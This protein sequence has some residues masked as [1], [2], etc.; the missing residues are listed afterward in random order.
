[1]ERDSRPTGNGENGESGGSGAVR[2]RVGLALGPLLL[3]ATLLLPAPAGLDVPAWRTAGVGLWMATWW[4]TEAIPIPATSLLP[5]VLLPP[6]GVTGIHATA[7]PYAHE[8]IFLFLGGFLVAIG[9]ERWGVP[10]RLALALVSRAG[11]RPE[12]VIAAFMAS[13]AFLSMWISNTATAMLM[14]PIGLSVLDLFGAAVQGLETRGT[15][16]RQREAR[17]REAQEREAR[18][19]EA[20]GSEVRGAGGGNFGRALMLAIAYA[21]SIGGLGTLIGT[22]PNAFLA[23]YLAQT[24]GFE[25]GFAGW[26]AFGLPLV[27]VGLP[28]AHVL[29]TRVVYPA[30]F[31]ELPGGVSAVR[32][33]LRELGSPGPAERRVAGVFAAVALLW[34][35]RPVLDGWIPALSDTG[36][37]IAAGL[38][39]F[40]IPSG[41]GGGALLRWRDAERLPWGVLVLF[42]G[43]LSLADAIHS[44]GLTAWIGEATAGLAGWPLVL[45]VGGTALVV[46]LLTELTSNTA[47]A[48]AFLPI[49]ASVAV[50]IGQ[51]PLLLTVPAAVTASCAFMLPVATPPNA[52]V[53]GSGVLT[54]PQMARAGIWLNLL[55]VVLATGAALLLLPLLFGV[56]FGTVPGWA[57]AG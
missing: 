35:S 37:A 40:L 10:R 53:Y 43:G 54:V 47:T 25:L 27:L 39:L 29:L 49:L 44:S 9:L 8:L 34:M 19:R 48:A 1:V 16:A 5:L 14:L 15:G 6:L 42:G 22:P 55:F 45:A 18:G 23:A 36:I 26:M 4:V 46:V 30:G 56:E 33:R 20:D 31:E 57:W 2:R 21:A 38:A 32:D 51:D 7:A 17:E 52:I 24:Y 12:A 11:A 50:G 3:A 41:E 13:T 28:A